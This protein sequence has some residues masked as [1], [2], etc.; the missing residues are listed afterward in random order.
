HGD[1]PLRAAALVL[2]PRRP[3]TQDERGAALKRLRLARLERVVPA[4]ETRQDLRLPVVGVGEPRM[5]LRGALEDGELLL[6][7]DVR[8]GWAVEPQKPAVGVEAPRLDRFLEDA[9]G[10]VAP[11]R[12]AQRRQRAR[13]RPARLDRRLAQVAEGVERLRLLDLPAGE[14]ALPGDDEVVGD[15]LL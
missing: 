8:P 14:V 5:A 12:G 15:V 11:A 6:R 3:A 13:N 10:L 1:G 2:D 4:L 7:R 9:V